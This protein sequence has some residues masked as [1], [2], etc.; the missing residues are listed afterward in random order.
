MVVPATDEEITHAFMAVRR[1][2]PRFPNFA[3]GFLYATQSSRRR[4]VAIPYNYGVAKLESANDLF[5]HAWVP[6]PTTSSNVVNMAAGRVLVGSFPQSSVSLNHSYSIIYVPPTQLVSSGVNSCPAIRSST[7][8]IG[9]IL[10]VKHGKRKAVINVDKEDATLVDMLQ[11]TANTVSTAFPPTLRLSVG[12]SRSL[13][14]APV[15]LSW[16]LGKQ[17]AGGGGYSANDAP[18][19]LDRKGAITESKEEPQ[20]GEGAELFIYRCSPGL[21]IIRPNP[22]AFAL[23]S[24]VRDHEK[25]LIRKGAGL[26]DLNL[27]AYAA[28][29][30]DGT[31]PIKMGG[32]RQ[33]KQK[34]ARQKS[35][36][37][38]GRR[39]RLRS[40]AVGNIVFGIPELLLCEIIPSCSL[41][42]VMALARTCHYSRRL[43]KSFFA[44]NQCHFLT[45]FIDEDNIATFYTVLKSS[46]SGMAGSFASSLLT[47]PYREVMTTNLNIFTPSG[48]LFIWRDFLSHINLPRTEKQ[49]GVDRR[50][51]HTTSKH[52]VYHAKTKDF[53]IS[54]SE[55]KD[56]SLFTPLIGAT[57]TLNTTIITAAKFYSL[58]ASLLSQRR[59]LEGWFPTPVRKAVAIGKRRYRSS[60]S[61]SSW[62]CPCGIHCPILWRQVRGLNHV[63]IFTWGGFEGKFGDFSEVGIPVTDT[64]LKWR[65]GDTCSNANCPWCHGNYFAVPRQ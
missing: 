35:Y 53:T 20:G 30:I 63:G 49:P 37:R 54:I 1:V 55:S 51:S 15:A 48:N 28:R 62:Q 64:D 33:K 26:N 8:W 40:A 39:M 31:S 18:E 2:E 44:A 38:E 56:N 52:V 46:S 27:C 29:A 22:G 13:S 10:V 17:C 24:N 14:A 60:F 57:T 11:S 16:T 41:E 43:V 9:N 34:V 19:A 45:P 23:S 21:C 25:Q 65:L 7:P 4:T 61:T 42:S 32:H 5:V 36:E 12:L 6:R 47:P 3:Y 58:Y 59:A 50:Y